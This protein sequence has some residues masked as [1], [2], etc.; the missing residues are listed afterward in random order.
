MH[1]NI[2]LLPA[3]EFPSDIPYMLHDYTIIV[4]KISEALYLLQQKLAMG[5][6]HNIDI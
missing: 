6:E 1:I 2:V 3:K 5:I 4:S